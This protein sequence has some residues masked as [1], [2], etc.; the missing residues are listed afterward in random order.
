MFHADLTSK[1][2]K[3]AR[4]RKLER[5]LPLSTGRLWKSVFPFLTGSCAPKKIRVFQ[6][7]IKK[8]EQTS[9]FDMGERTH[10]KITNEK[11]GTLH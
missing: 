11:T 3:L 7:D 2:L 8:T 6:D 4:E 10:D 5:K 1:K 9:M